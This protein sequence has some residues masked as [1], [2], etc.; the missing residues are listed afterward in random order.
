LS[1][2]PNCNGPI[3][4]MNKFVPFSGGV[5]AHIQW[6]DS[7]N[8]SEPAANTFG[9]CGVGNIRGPWLKTLDMS[10][11]KGFTINEH[12]SLL[13]RVDAFNAF[14]NSIWTFSGGPAGGSFDQGSGS[15][16]WITG[17][18]GARQLQLALKFIF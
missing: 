10:L 17:T 2:L 7:S 15:L 18:Q 4:I 9:T 12:K 8:V 3:N 1:D 16:G 13:F 6:F 11:Q 5:P 14:N